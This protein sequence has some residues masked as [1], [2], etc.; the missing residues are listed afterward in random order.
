MAEGYVRHSQR[1][2]VFED[3]PE[4]VYPILLEREA[5]RE[6][7]PR[8][9][10]TAPAAAPR[11]FTATFESGVQGVEIIV[12]GESIGRTPGAKTTRALGRAYR[13]EARAEGYRNAEGTFGSYGDPAVTVELALEKLPDTKQVRQAKPARGVGHLVCT[14]NPQGAEIFIDGK[15]TGRRT[16][17]PATDPIELP[18]GKHRVLFEIAGVVSEV[19]TITI[20]KDKTV[21][22]QDVAV[23]RDRDL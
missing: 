10:E 5:P 9:Q 8:P 21:T 7:L 16:P 20:E 22:L 11:E 18:P 23:D 17:V 1:I 2:T 13:Y 3:A 6:P 4:A 14:S 12:E 15:P 19:K